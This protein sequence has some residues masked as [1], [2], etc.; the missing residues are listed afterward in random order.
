[1]TLI[2]NHSDITTLI[3]R[4]EIYDAVERAHADLARGDAF[5]PQPSAMPL[6]NGGNSIP[7]TAA[8]AQSSSVKLLSDMPANAARGLPT[9]RSTIILSCAETGECEAVLDGRAI[10]AIRTAA[11]SAVA[12]EYLSRKSSTVLGVV[13]AGTLAVE[14]TRAIARVRGIEKVL[15]WSRSAT[16]IRT[17]EERIADLN[18]AVERS[19]SPRAVTSAVDI[20]CTL[21]P[22]HSPIVSGD[23]FHPGLHVN[24]VGAPPRGDWR[25]IDSAGMRV[26]SLF[27]DATSTTLAKSGDALLA[28]AEGAITAEDLHTEIGHVITGQKPGRT[29]SDQITLFNSVGIGLQD[30]VTARIL[31]SRARAA[32]VGTELDL[33]A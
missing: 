10:T 16:T 3:D 32:G 24:A 7:M 31:L 9:Q 13:G 19:E 28:I 15:V 30:L 18:L 27:V 20:L 22:S 2:L 17:F 11:A 12:T 33:T 5:N 14:H 6:P 21:T 29:S 8:T 25:E 23:W 26:A 4:S 1:M